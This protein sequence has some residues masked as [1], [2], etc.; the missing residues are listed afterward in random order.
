[1]KRIVVALGGNAILTDNPTAQGQ[2]KALETTAKQL[3][4]FIKQ[5]Y[6]VVITHGNG[7][8]V[9]NLLL[10]QED[11]ASDQNPAMP[12]DTV[13][14]M[15]QGEIGLWLANALNMELI[16]AGLDKKRVATIMTRTLVDKDDPA[17]NN[18]SKPIGP[19]YT[20]QEAEKIKS[21]NPT[22]TLVEDSGRGY[23]RVVASPRPIDVLESR[24]IAHLVDQDTILVAG[25]GG[26]VPVIEVDGFYVGSEA[27]IDKDFT[28]EKIAELIH[29]DALIILTAVDHVAINFGQDNQ[30]EL[31]YITVSELKQH[32]LENQFAKGSMLPKVLAGIDFVENTG[33]EAIITG[34]NNI[35]NLIAHNSGTHIVADSKNEKD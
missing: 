33:N 14:S 21:K 1:M 17:F 25:G 27:I 12:L 31:G 20:T 11:G 9:G 7:P 24:E 3:I 5:G 13:G 2:A 28:S 19:F 26:G 22:W 6:Q 18:P 30:Q 10:Q 32:I 29:A 8:Q 15:T 35:N 23:R 34:L 16:H 4:S